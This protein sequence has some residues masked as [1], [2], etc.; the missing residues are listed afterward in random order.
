MSICHL[1]YLYEIVPVLSVVSPEREG[2][3]RAEQTGGWDE[4][5]VFY[6]GTHTKLY[7]HEVVIKD[8]LYV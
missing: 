2:D 7:I 4:G 6:P 8:Q 1:L 5:S 3:R